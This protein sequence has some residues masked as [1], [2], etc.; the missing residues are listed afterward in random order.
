MKS[1]EKE[2]KRVKNPHILQI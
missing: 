2:K 1:F